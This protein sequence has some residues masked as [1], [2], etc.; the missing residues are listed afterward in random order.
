VTRGETVRTRRAGGIAGIAARRAISDF[1]GDFRER[2]LPGA[3]LG[4]ALIANFLAWK[5]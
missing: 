1:R 2:E 4:L 5:P 3:G